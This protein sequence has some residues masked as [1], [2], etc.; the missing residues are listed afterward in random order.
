MKAERLAQTK[1]RP[2]VVSL[3]Q[4]RQEP[5]SLVAPVVLSG[6]TIGTFQLHQTQDDDVAYAWTDDDLALIEAILDQVAQSA[7]NLRLFDET[8]ERADYER[9]VGEVTQRIRQA[10]DLES[11]TQTAAEAIST[12]LGVSD[13]MV[14]L[15]IDSKQR[16]IEGNGNK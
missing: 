3:A 2:T 6:Q 9:L 13:G 12:V 11:L 10:P 5:Q 15:N 1:E 7:E 4:N 14:Q 8:R 16:N